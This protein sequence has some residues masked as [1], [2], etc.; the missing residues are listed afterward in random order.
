MKGVNRMI[1]SFVKVAIL[2][3]I[4]A[5]IFVGTA[6]ILYSK[7]SSVKGFLKGFSFDGDRD[8][9]VYLMGGSV[10]MKI[11]PWIV[12]LPAS[13]LF[14]QEAMSIDM[15]NVYAASVFVMTQC[16]LSEFWLYFNEDWMKARHMNALSLG[17]IGTS[18]YFGL[19]ATTAQFIDVFGGLTAV[20][21]MGLTM[22]FNVTQ[23]SALEGCVRFL[24]ESPCRYCV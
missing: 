1:T 16:I 9:S 5:P 4:C 18:G 19:F 14:K 23:I 15:G 12:L 22:L 21:L 6:G 7:R 24:K 13:N 8:V 20:Q 3:F 2:S 11:L 17:L 10:F